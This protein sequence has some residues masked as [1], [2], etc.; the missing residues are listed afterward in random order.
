MKAYLGYENSDI[1]K[2]S[3]MIIIKRL[4]NILSLFTSNNYIKI[5]NITIENSFEI[6]LED[7]DYTIGKI[8]EFMLYDE[9]LT[10]KKILSYCA[11]NKQ[12]PHINIS[13]ILLSF[14]D[15]TDKDKVNTIFQDSIN[16]SINIYNKIY[17][18]F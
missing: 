14:K 2:K 9:Y 8:L 11:F 12:H 6:Y 18:L 17:D 7:E 10:N 13:T 16:R 4:N 5:S 15:E 1:I 3:I